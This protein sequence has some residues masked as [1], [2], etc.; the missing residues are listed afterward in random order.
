MLS[1]KHA[2]TS[3]H[4]INICKVVNNFLVY[5]AKKFSCYRCCSRHFHVHVCV[6]MLK[7]VSTMSML[8]FWKVPNTII[9]Y[10]RFFNPLT[11][12][13]LSALAK[14][15]NT[16]KRITCIRK[17]YTY[18]THQ[19]TPHTCIHSAHMWKRSY[20]SKLPIQISYHCL[21]CVSKIS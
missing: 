1:H 19:S 14:M 16:K 2:P 7:R 4:R 20:K 13:S 18:V 11:S 5:I 3:A 15:M 6:R 21:V 12:R 10:I 8:C 9:W 17:I